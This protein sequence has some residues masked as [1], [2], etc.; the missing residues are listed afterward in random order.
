MQKAN[1]TQ[2]DNKIKILVG[3]HKPSLLFKND[4]LTPIH[5]GRDIADEAAKDG[6]N[7]LKSQQWLND[8]LIGDN[9]GDNISRKNRSYNEMTAMYWAWKNIEQLGNPEYIGFM[10]YRRQF[11]FDDNVVPLF[12]DIPFEAPDSQFRIDTLSDSHIATL[13]NEKVIT[14]ALKD[15]DVI[16]PRG[17]HWDFTVYDQYLA[18]SGQAHQIRDL[19]VTLQV[20]KEEFKD[21]YPIAEAY[22]N[23]NRHYWWNMFVMRTD[24]F[25]QYCEFM[26]AVLF[27]AEEFINILEPS[28]S[29]RTVVQKRIYGFLSERLSGIFF[30]YLRNRSDLRIKEKYTILEM[31]LQK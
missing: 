29:E 13:F 6:K 30:T 17:I 25:I 16:L 9:T 23:G 11:I 7:D 19:D 8:H 28:M 4:I 21:Y 26:F 12:K 27:R 31:F 14:D 22:M 2:A 10:H 5:L 18:A 20:L 3:Y 15:T 24:V 1:S